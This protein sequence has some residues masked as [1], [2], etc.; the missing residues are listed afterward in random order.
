MPLQHLRKHC[1][2]VCKK[3]RKQAAN[4]YSG[5]CSTL[6]AMPPPASAEKRADLPARKNLPAGEG[7]SSPGVG[8][9]TFSVLNGLRGYLLRAG[10]CWSHGIF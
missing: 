6:L 3:T 2:L 10:S 5:F 7:K 4:I 1:H 9:F 8:E